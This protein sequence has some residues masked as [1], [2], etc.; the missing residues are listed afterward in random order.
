MLIFLWSYGLGRQL[1]Y[2]QC[3]LHWQHLPQ[4]LRFWYRQD[5]EH[6]PDF[7]PELFG[8]GVIQQLHRYLFH[9]QH[10]FK[11]SL[12]QHHF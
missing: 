4:Q 10:H 6:Y 1:C 12:C 5:C 3:G 11:L 8:Y 7:E 9:C 2:Q